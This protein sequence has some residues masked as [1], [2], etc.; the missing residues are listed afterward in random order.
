[1]SKTRNWGHGAVFSAAIWAGAGMVSAAEGI[2][3]D[4]ATLKAQWETYGQYSVSSPV[5]LAP[6]RATDEATGADGATYRLTSLHPAVN[7]WYLLEFRPAQGLPVQTYHLE[8]ADAAV[9]TLSLNDADAPAIMVSGNGGEVACRPWDGAPSA[10]QVASQSGLPY[11]P[12]C[13]G[14]VYLR[15]EVAGSRTNREAVSDFLRDHV[16]FGDKLVNLIKGAFFEDAFLE[17]AETVEGDAGDA[18]AALGQARLDRQPIMRPNW[19]IEVDGADNG[20]EAGAWYGVTGVKG[21]YGSVMKPGYISQEITSERNGANWIDG[22]EQNADV[23]LVAFDLSQLE[24]GYELGTDH[25]NLNWSSRPRRTGNDWNIP[26]PDG[27]ARAA[28]L[29]RN[30]ML[31]PSHTSR[32]VGAFAGGFKRDHGAFRFGDYATF[33]KGHHYGFISN[34]VTFSKLIPNLATLYVTVE[35]EVG[36]KTWTE[37]DA[38]MIPNLQFARQNGVPLVVRDPDTGASV[39]GDR[40]TSW[41][42]GNWSGSAEAELRT[43]RAGTCLKEAGDR[44]FLLYGYFSTA[45]PSG[46]ARTFQ[47]YDCDYGMLLDMNSPE[48]TYLA[49]YKQNDEG[50][51]LTPMHLNRYMAESDPWANNQQIPRFVGFADNRDFFYLLRKE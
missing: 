7:R 13:N 41:G 11:A 3:T 32:A 24:L 35:G 31:N 23:Y 20:L 10:L 42:G 45:T 38:D 17:D 30:G 4:A 8:N 21:V 27:F 40:V 34:G 49:V 15:N 18:V 28:P 43:L 51:G 14:A 44:K 46:M 9:W 29:V 1:M 47:A 16:V 36:M 2:E 50:D 39:P 12:M 26:G 19:S 48:L 33:N 25:P 6:M 22:V 5:D 37:A